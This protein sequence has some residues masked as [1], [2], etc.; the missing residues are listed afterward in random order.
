[1]KKPVTL[2]IIGVIMLTVVSLL[3]VFLLNKTV[4]NVNNTEQ[5]MIEHIGQSIII[6]Q[7]T[8]FV[9]DY[10]IMNGTLKLNNGTTIS[11]KAFDKLKQNEQDSN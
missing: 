11:M 6:K 1:M 9:V 2:F 3:L 10:S 7:D 5:Q 8:L 4:N